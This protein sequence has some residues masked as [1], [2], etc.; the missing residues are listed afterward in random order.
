MVINSSPEIRNRQRL[1]KPRAYNING[2]PPVP[3]PGGWKS[4]SP[5]S[6]HG[7]FLIQL[8]ESQEVQPSAT[9]PEVWNKY[10][11]LQVVDPSVSSRFFHK[12]IQRANSHSSIATDSSTPPPSISFISSQQTGLDNMSQDPSSDSDST[13]SPARTTRMVSSRVACVG[14][15]ISSSA[16]TNTY[17]T[18]RM[19]QIQDILLCLF[20]SQISED[21]ISG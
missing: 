11:Q 4:S 10:S 2:S 20:R 17:V 7:P 16:C 5:D 12:C 3:P 6:S 9:P 8:I 19:H 13:A 18:S 1:G 14:L 21:K 15:C